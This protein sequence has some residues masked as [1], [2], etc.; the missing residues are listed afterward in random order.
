LA[1]SD[2]DADAEPELAEPLLDA[3]VVSPADVAASPAVPVLAPSPESV[4]A[5]AF[6]IDDDR[7]F[8]AQPLPLKCT[9]GGANAL[10][11]LFS[12]PQAGQKRGPG[13]SIPWMT[14]VR[15][16]QFEQR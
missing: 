8:F 9:A 6:V 12:A 10:R 7:S 2:D 3:E 13:A 14:S 11:M 15:A 4:L 5:R 16:P 1:D